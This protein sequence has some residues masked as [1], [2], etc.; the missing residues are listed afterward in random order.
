[1]E[2]LVDGFALWGPDDRLILCNGR[3]RELYGSGGDMIVPGVR[4]EE[5]LRGM[6]KQAVYAPEGEALLSFVL[7]RLMGRRRADGAVEEA[8]ADGRWL[9]VRERRAA[10]G[11]LTALVSEFTEYK[12]RE[13]D[14]IAANESASAANQ[15]KD[16][17]LAN[18]SHEFRT[19]LNAILGFT[20]LMLGD[21]PS[22]IENP[23]HREYLG[24][25]QSAGSH[26][27]QLI[28]D[29]LDAAKIGSEQFALREDD[30][31]VSTTVEDVIR[32]VAESAR[33]AGVRLERAIQPAL[34]EIRADRLRLRQILLNLLSNAIKFTPAGGIVTVSVGTSERGLDIVV[35]DSGIGMDAAEIAKALEP[36]GQSRP[37]LHDIFGGTGLGLPLARS[38]AELHGGT[39]A[40]ESAPGRGTSVAVSLPASRIRPG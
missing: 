5:L 20:D 22:R 32:M 39:L 11:H 28:N 4:F 18:V 2:A 16:D 35:K 33:S 27:L 10:D 7:D 36:F 3:F 19:P 6:A 25:V 34:P 23:K 15:A 14:L 31:D 29:I 38:L 13:Q 8:L 9:R 21:F 1:M 37:P 12:R 26:L 40:I 17:F 30:V 24:D